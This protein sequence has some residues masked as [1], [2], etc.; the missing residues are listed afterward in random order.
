MIQNTATIE[1]T[2]TP[3]DFESLSIYWGNPEYDL[4]WDCV[5]ILPNWIH[6]WWQA[7]GDG[8][9][10]CLFSVRQGNDVT[11]IAPLQVRDHIVSF[12][13]SIDVCDCLDFIVSP[14]KGDLFFNTLLDYLAQKDIIGLDLRCL[15]PDSQAQKDLIPIA[16]ERG[17]DVV[18][19]PDG[20]S[21]EVDLPMTWDDYL[22]QL[23]SKQR[24]ELKRKFRRLYEAGDTAFQVYNDMHNI[25]ER[26]DIF[27]KLFRESRSDK[28]EFM[29]PKM[30]S[31]F[32]AMISAMTKIE[33]L[34]LGVL[35]LND[36][37]VAAVLFFDYNNIFY[38]YNNGYDLNFRSLSVGVLCKALSIQHGIAL[39]RKTFDFLKGPEPYKYRLGGKEVPLTRCRIAIK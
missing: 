33:I 1:T 19:E 4:N 6:A 14:G 35:F 9:E 25:P 7:F 2:V 30:E 22:G 21:L 3:E 27:F 31:F 15:R 37:P 16:R 32:S 26:S 34:K 23:N 11:G 13:G 17:Y 5:F 36:A 20:L 12:I 8:A 18:C 38:L 39:G 24:H 29:T 28:T 10:P